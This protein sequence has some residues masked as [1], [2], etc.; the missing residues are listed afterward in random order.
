MIGVEFPESQQ[1]LIKV[2][3]FEKDG[4]SYRDV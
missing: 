3:N 4:V 1:G 2:Y